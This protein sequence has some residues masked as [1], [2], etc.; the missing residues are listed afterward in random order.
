M[1]IKEVKQLLKPNNHKTQERETQIFTNS[2]NS[3]VNQIENQFAAKG[4]ANDTNKWIQ[5]FI[6]QFISK[7][8]LIEYDSRH[9]NKKKQNH[10]G[11]GRPLKNGEG[12]EF[13]GT[14]GIQ[15]ILV[16]FCRASCKLI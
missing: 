13:Y 14:T 16:P 15:Q 11:I 2:I 3:F 1:R 4:H 5:Q 9:S 7:T 12:R 6:C 10:T 8:N